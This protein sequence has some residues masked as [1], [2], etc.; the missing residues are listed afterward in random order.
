MTNRLL[1]VGSV[2]LDDLTTHA[3]Q[4]TEVLGGA[5]TYIAIAASRFCAVDL[6]AVVGSDFPERH[7]LLLEQHKID[8][9]GLEHAAGRTFRWAGQY[10]E[11]FSS[12]TTL[13]TELGVFE[14]FDPKLPP[15]YRSSRFVLLG[16][17]HPGLQLKVLDQLEPGAFVAA[18]TM[19]LWIDITPQELGQLISRVDLLI[20]NDEEA[21]QLTG[22]RQV[23]V[24]AA[25]ILRRGPKLLIIKRGEHGAYL[26]GKD[27]LFFAPALPLPEVVDPTGAGDTFAGG[28]MGVVAASGKSSAATIKKG[29]MYGAACASAA[30]EGFGADFLAAA[31]LALIEERYQQLRRLVSLD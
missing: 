5:A 30:V 13:S 31:P 15:T 11:D 23:S 26:F 4:R 2:A 7:V 22:E 28:L 16:N 18:D 25:Q 6:V 29:M 27:T 21:H 17:I 20:I 9:S 14:H 19:N 8:L 1:V 10:A 3:G 12:R 24:A